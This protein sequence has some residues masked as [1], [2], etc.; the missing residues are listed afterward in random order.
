MLSAIFYG[1]RTS[2]VVGALSAVF[3]LVDRHRARA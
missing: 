3:A 1:L 2:L